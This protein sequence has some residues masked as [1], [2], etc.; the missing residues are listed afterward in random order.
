MRLTISIAGDGRLSEIDVLPDE[1]IENVS[2]LIEVEFGILVPQQQISYNNAVLAQPSLKLSELGIGDGDLLVV[3]KV[4]T[5]PA[6][7][8]SGATASSG[9]AGAGRG[10]GGGRRRGGFGG[11]PRVADLDPSLYPALSWEDLPEGLSPETLYAILQVNRGMM[12]EIERRDPELAA[13]AHVGASALQ[14]IMLQRHIAR[15]L[16]EVERATKLAQLESRIATDPFDAEAQLELEKI[17]EKRNIEENYSMAMEHMPEAFAR[18]FMLY[19]P[20]KINGVTVKVFVDS[21]AQSTIL[22]KRC[23]ERCNIMRLV[24]THFAGVAVGVGSSKIIGR[25]HM[26]PLEVQSHRLPCTF[27]VIEKNSIDCLFGLDMLRRYQACIDLRAGVLRL[28]VDGTEVAVPF[29][30]EADIPKDEAGG[31]DFHED[32]DGGGGGAASTGGGK[33]SGSDSSTISSS[34]GGG[35]ALPALGSAAGGFSAASAAPSVSGSAASSGGAAAASVPPSLASIDF[36]AA[37]SA[38]RGASTAGSRAPAAAGGGLAG[39]GG[40]A[41]GIVPPRASPALGP[42]SPPFTIDFTALPPA[43]ASVT[44][45]SAAGAAALE[46]ARRAAAPASGAA[47]PSSSAAGGSGAA[48]GGSAPAGATATPL[49]GGGDAWL[50]PATGAASA[51]TAFPDV[52]VLAALGFPADKCVRALTLCGGDAAAAAELLPFLP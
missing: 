14:K 12:V 23:A 27:T 29:L 31:D 42:A 5:R 48:T 3:H 41:S 13:A 15:A 6:A 52:S 30:G 26:A 34:G 19:I 45:A 40:G 25:V 33:A 11:M 16:P 17:I 24:D 50:P 8:G 46:R 47:P 49:P 18:V 2:A 35:S 36:S 1:S 10:G 37:L 44:A 9:S 51:A 32:G 28:L 39:S 7:G 22:S 43:A 38:A 4:S 21:G 20:A